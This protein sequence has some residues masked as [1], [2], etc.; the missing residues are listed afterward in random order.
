MTQTIALPVEEA[1]Q[2]GGARRTVIG[3]A[4][5]LG[6]NETERGRV[7]L[8]VTELA[9][10]LARHARAGLLLVHPL[11]RRGV[12]GIELLALDQGP[13]MEHVGE[14][15]RDGYSTAGTAGNGMGAIARLSD[16]FEIY[17]LPSVGTA[18]LCRLWAAPLPPR[19]H[20]IQ[21]GA[22]ALPKLGEEASGD[23]WSVVRAGDRCRVIVADGLGH[24][25][26]AAQ[27]A[28]EAV[29][30]FHEQS[31]RSPKEIL[32]AS[33]RALRSTRGAA[34]AIAEINLPQQTVRFA[35][36]GNISA[37]LLPVQHASQPRQNWVSFNGT[38]GHEVRKIQEYTYD[39]MTEGVMVMHSDGLSSQWRLD[40]YPG[41]LSKH[42]S[43]IAGVLYRDFHR[44]RDD[45]TVVVMRQVPI[46]SLPPAL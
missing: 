25:I 33:H 8:V 3:L 23:A 30:V 38:I 41:L 36:V 10:N 29:R 12:V 16:L 18:I 17:T 42:P 20:P 37:M 2:A 31:D 43:L 6:L 13:G 7:G 26:L 27:A 15:L 39:W 44:D 24:G 14:C 34:V 46:K 21:L 35:G 11:E 40:Q 9:N 19:T 45:I 5:Q 1:S 28:N 32:E 22:V 4:T